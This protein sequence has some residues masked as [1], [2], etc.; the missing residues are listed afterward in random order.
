[1][2]SNWTDHLQDTWA[3]ENTSLCYFIRSNRLII[4]YNFALDYS[5]FTLTD[6]EI[7]FNT[8][9]PWNNWTYVYKS[10]IQFVV[11]YLKVSGNSVNL[12]FN[13]SFETCTEW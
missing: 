10:C 2:S 5:K 7:L 13:H 8:C 11:R 12:S 9:S 3:S 6:N 4:N 1:M